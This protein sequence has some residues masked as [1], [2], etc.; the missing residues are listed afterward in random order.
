[1]RLASLFELHEQPAHLLEPFRGREAEKGVELCEIDAGR[2]DPTD[3]VLPRKLALSFPFH[4]LIS[5][6]AVRGPPTPVKTLTKPVFSAR[7][8]EPR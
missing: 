5:A 1:M 6:N 2:N 3:L 7:P 8:E 4:A